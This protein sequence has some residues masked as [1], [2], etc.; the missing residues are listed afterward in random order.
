MSSQQPPSLGAG[1]QH[2]EPS[3]QYDGGAHEDWSMFGIGD[4]L[5]PVYE[6]SNCRGL[7]RLVLTCVQCGG[8]GF[9]LGPGAMAPVQKGQNSSHS[10]PGSS[11]RRSNHR[12]SH[13]N[14]RQAA[15]NTRS[16][17]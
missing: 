6:C 7:H 16:S 1:Q 3:Y 15:S 13:G 12:R 8:T 9:D 11:N 4:E 10:S 2:Q 5:R 14:G 17:R